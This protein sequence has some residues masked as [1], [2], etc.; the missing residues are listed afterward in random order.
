MPKIFFAMTAIWIAGRTRHQ[1]ERPVERGNAGRSAGTEASPQPP[2]LASKMPDPR[3]VPAPGTIEVDALTNMLAI[4]SAGDR[5]SHLNVNQ[6]LKV[7]RKGP[8][9]QGC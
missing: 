4:P 6:I 1:A 8:G 9:Q 2:R 5:T 7:A 3:A